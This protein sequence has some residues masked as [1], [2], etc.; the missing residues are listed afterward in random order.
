MPNSGIEMYFKTC[1]K[2]KFH[3]FC[4]NTSN[5]GLIMPFFLKVLHPVIFEKTLK[6]I[7][8]IKTHGNEKILQEKKCIL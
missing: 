6:K 4:Y 3:L 5:V 8:N 7:L 2:D 1:I